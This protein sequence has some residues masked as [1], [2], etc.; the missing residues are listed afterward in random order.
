MRVRPARCSGET[1]LTSAPAPAAA[2]RADDRPSDLPGEWQPLLWRHPR[3]RCVVGESV[4][5]EFGV[6][7]VGLGQRCVGLD[8]LA[9][10]DEIHT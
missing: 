1:T 10:P 7:Q 3:H 9:A 5:V 6:S 8:P 4:H 2:P